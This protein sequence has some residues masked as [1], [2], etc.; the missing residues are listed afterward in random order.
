MRWLPSRIQAD[1][2]Q[3]QSL[4]KQCTTGLETNLGEAQEAISRKRI[5][6]EDGIRIRELRRDTALNSAPLTWHGNPRS[7]HWL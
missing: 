7:K 5:N 1:E 4:P 2:C 6:A 3:V